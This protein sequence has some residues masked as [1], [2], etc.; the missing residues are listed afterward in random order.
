M[1]RLKQTLNEIISENVCRKSTRFFDPVTGVGSPGERVEVLMNCPFLGVSTL[2]LPVSLLKTEVGR[3]VIES[4]GVA[5]FAEDRG[6]TREAV[7][8]LFELVRLR[9]DF[10]YW[11]SKYGL[12]RPKTG[13]DNRPLILNSAQRKLVGQLEMMRTA[14]KPVRAILLKARQWGGSTVI[15]LYMVLLL[16]AKQ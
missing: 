9:H 5:R 4:G 3:S 13:G 14:H 8:E 1:S 2:H 6:L 15:Q 12:I 16:S 11:A 7:A 10:P